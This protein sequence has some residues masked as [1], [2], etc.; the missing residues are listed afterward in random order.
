MPTTIMTHQPSTR[1]LTAPTPG[2]FQTNPLEHQSLLQQARI[3]YKRPRSPDRLSPWT[4]PTPSSTSLLLSSSFSSSCN[5][6]ITAFNSSIDLNDHISGMF[7]VPEDGGFNSATSTPRSLHSKSAYFAAQANRYIL[8]TSKNKS[9]HKAILVQE[10]NIKLAQQLRLLDPIDASNV[11]HA[12]RPQTTGTMGRKR[13]RRPSHDR[14]L[15][16]QDMVEV[17]QHV[18]T[19]RGIT[20]SGEQTSQEDKIS[21]ALVRRATQ[22]NE[23][24]RQPGD[25]RGLSG[26]VRVD[27]KLNR[28]RDPNQMAVLLTSLGMK[29]GGGRKSSAKNKKNQR[30]EKN[31]QDQD[32]EQQARTNKFPMLKTPRSKKKQRTKWGNTIRDRQKKVKIKRA[33]IIQAELQRVYDVGSTFKLARKQKAQ[34]DRLSSR[35]VARGWNRTMW[36]YIACQHFAVALKRGRDMKRIKLQREIAQIKIASNYRRKQCMREL[37]ARRR[38][39]FLLKFYLKRVVRQW[40]SKRRKHDADVLLNW[41]STTNSFA[42][43]V[44][45]Y[46]FLKN[47]ATKIQV[48]WYAFRTNKRKLIKQ[49]SSQMHDVACANHNYLQMRRT[50]SAKLPALSAIPTWDIRYELLGNIIRPMRRAWMDT[51]MPKYNLDR[52]NYLN[53]KSRY[54]RQKQ[55]EEMENKR[56]RGKQK[57]SIDLNTFLIAPICPRFHADVSDAKLLLCWKQSVVLLKKPFLWLET[58]ENIQAWLSSRKAGSIN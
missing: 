34:N 29:F 27:Y 39:D 43:R 10:Q 42:K 24:K 11:T 31:E 1:P 3:N 41:L 5:N 35:K 52:Q 53:K 21:K 55:K 49:L 20:S 58:K 23:V 40:Q 19:L 33:Q 12:N 15:L 18:K 13:H 36:R 48:A 17:L 28:F 8:S 16:L 50:S 2:F 38:A 45:G 46:N 44:L 26:R 22:E 30:G 4:K 56:S 25:M 51:A 6:D 7:D 14:A 9:K 47:N 54:E 32:Q 37:Q 57:V